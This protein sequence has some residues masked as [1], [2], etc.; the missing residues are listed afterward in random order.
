MLTVA[1][2]TVIAALVGAIRLI[3]GILVA[4]A[5]PVHL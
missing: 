2:L 1:R 5:E 4:R 3:A